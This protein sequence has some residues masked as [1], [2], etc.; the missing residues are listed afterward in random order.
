MQKRFIDLLSDISQYIEKY[1]L[2]SQYEVLISEISKKYADSQKG[3]VS[4]HLEQLVSLS[5]KLD[6]TKDRKNNKGRIQLKGNGGEIMPLPYLDFNEKT[7]LDHIADE[8]YQRLLCFNLKSMYY[9]AVFSLI[10]GN[11]KDED[12]IILQQDLKF[13]E[14]LTELNSRFQNNCELLY[15]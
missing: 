12:K 2:S 3:I 10:S 11:I 1:L 15:K 4:D 8:Y 5:K 14:M 9:R 7:I 13:K 6:Y